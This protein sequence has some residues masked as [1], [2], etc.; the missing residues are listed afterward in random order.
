MTTSSSYLFMKLPLVTSSSFW[1]PV[2]ALETVDGETPMSGV[3][4][5][6]GPL[7]RGLPH[8]LHCKDLC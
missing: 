3:S 5:A 2:H 8:Y 7:S 6:Q 4:P 1:F